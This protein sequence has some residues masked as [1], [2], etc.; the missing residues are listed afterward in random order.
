MNQLEHSVQRLVFCFDGSAPSSSG[1]LTLNC[2]Q[3]MR[4]GVTDAA[5]ALH[6]AMMYSCISGELEVLTPSPDLPV[7]AAASRAE[8]GADG[9]RPSA[10]AASAAM[11]PDADLLRPL[12]AGICRG[13]ALLAT[14]TPALSGAI[15]SRTHRITRLLGPDRPAIMPAL[16]QSLDAAVCSTPDQ[17]L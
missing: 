16:Q 14:C 15:T 7:L 3:A 10:L 17:P 6:R 13:S 8:F 2:A 4:S 11:P 5:P 12:G 9:P 1:C